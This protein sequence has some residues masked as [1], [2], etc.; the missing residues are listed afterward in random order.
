MSTKYEVTNTVT[1][2]TTELEA[3]SG[4][5]GPDVIHIA[6]LLKEQGVFTFDPG[7]MAT[8]STGTAVSTVPLVRCSKEW[9]SSSMANTTPP[10]GVLNAAATPAA[11]PASTRARNC[12]P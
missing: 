4:T 12:R 7:F 5:I 11:P 8:A 1:G 6:P 10:S 3:T 2:K 9:L